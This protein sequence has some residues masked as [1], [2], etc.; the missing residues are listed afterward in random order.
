MYSLSSFQKYGSSRVPGFGAGD[1]SVT[2]GRVENGISARLDS[3]LG[4][5]T[6]VVRATIAL[7]VNVI[8]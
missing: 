6:I 7:K 8:P 5:V 4:H 3:N 1:Y 2:P